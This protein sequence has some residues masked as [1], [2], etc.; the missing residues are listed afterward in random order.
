MNTAIIAKMTLYQI[1]WFFVVY[2]ILGW[3]LEVIYHAVTLGKVI[4][5]GFL[6]GPVCP[7]YGFGMLAVLLFFDSLQT[8]VSDSNFLF[9]YSGGVVLATAV[10]LIGGW[11]LDKLFHARWWDYS[12]K[13][14]NLNGYICLE[15]S[16]IWGFIVVLAY[17]V[18]HPTVAGLTVSLLPVWLG[19]VLLGILYLTYIADLFV[20]V[21]TVRGMNRNMEEIEELRKKLRIVSDSMSKKI[22]NESIHS[23]QVLE[24]KKAQAE[25]AATEQLE[26]AEKAQR[27]REQAAG[28]V[29]REYE[30]YTEA[31]RELWLREHEKAREAME[32]QMEKRS[33]ELRARYQEVRASLYRHPHF[34]AARLMKAFPNAVHREHPDLFREFREKIENSGKRDS[35]G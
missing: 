26:L 15:F 19:S 35:N 12:D 6:N 13:P 23:A 8:D 5:R 3:C 20:T 30:T 11:A 2:S 21:A 7:V 24:E 17:R 28:E 16:L 9:L 27:A 10:E 31:Q 18:I 33:A 1:L 22:G 25:R 4:N 32:H 29:L 14:F 34:G